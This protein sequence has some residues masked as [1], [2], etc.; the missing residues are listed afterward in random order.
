M[1][2][3][4]TFNGTPGESH[5]TVFPWITPTV[6]LGRLSLS[7]WQLNQDH[8]GQLQSSIHRDGD[9]LLDESRLAGKFLGI[10][11]DP[12]PG[13]RLNCPGVGGETPSVIIPD[14]FD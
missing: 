12:F 7:G 4:N 14:S 2:A 10:N 8:S 13:E 5:E 3:G 11:P 9:G 6:V 1:P